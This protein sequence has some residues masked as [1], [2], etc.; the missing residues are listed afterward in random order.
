M[1]RSPA[2][3]APS[4]PVTP[5]SC[6]IVPSAVAD[7]CLALASDPLSIVQGN[8]AQA[9]GPKLSALNTAAG[10]GD[11]SDDVQV[12]GAHPSNYC[13]QESGGLAIAE[14]ILDDAKTVG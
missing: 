5:K 14:I 12:L 10:F 3:T 1:D 2:N 9:A 11:D 8:P 13:D 4:T 7:V 6:R